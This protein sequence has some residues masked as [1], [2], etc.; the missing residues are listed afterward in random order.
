M[1]FLGLKTA[2][3]EKYDYACGTSSRSTKLIHGGVRYLQK[4]IFNL[5]IEQVWHLCQVLLIISLLEFICDKGCSFIL[6]SAYHSKLFSVITVQVGE[7]G[8]AW[9]SQPIANCTTS[10]RSTANYATSLQ[11]RFPNLAKKVI[12]VVFLIENC[13]QYVIFS[14]QNGARV[15]WHLKFAFAFF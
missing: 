4:A 9:K 14:P 3:V 1:E 12:K 7:G 11:V 6:K 5:D 8:L 2:L 15:W 10:L 13:Q